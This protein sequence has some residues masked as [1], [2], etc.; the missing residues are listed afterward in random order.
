M[1]P[2]P[3]DPALTDGSHPDARLRLRFWTGGQ[4]RDEVWISAD[5]QGA[6]DIAMTV[7]TYHGHLADL[8]DAAGVPWLV[9]VFDPA[10]PTEQ[11]YL[12]F[13]TDKDGMIEPAPATPASWRLLG[14]RYP[15]TGGRT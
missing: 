4:L 14:R 2:R 6:G 12:R 9:E 13:G 5:A 15:P 11:G 3:D 8:A 1:S 10:A 7:A